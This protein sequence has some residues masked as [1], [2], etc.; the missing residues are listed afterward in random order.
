M[1]FDQGTAQL[2]AAPVSWLR[3]L[4]IFRISFTKAADGEIS[5]Q[6]V[7]AI[8][9]PAGGPCSRDDPQSGYASPSSGVLTDC[10]LF[11]P[12]ICRSGSSA[13]FFGARVLLLHGP[14]PWAG[15]TEG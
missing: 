1:W 14:K 9:D 11:G 4:A 13:S 2:W 12:S 8:F 5:D 6:V 7:G 3:R 10:L 15:S